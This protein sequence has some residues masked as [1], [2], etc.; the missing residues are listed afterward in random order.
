MNEH[1]LT[2]DLSDLN[3]LTPQTIEQSMAALESGQVVHFPNYSFLLDKTETALLSESVLHPKHKNISYDYRKQRLAG[4]STLASPE[5]STV[6][7]LFMHRFAEYARQLITEIVPRYSNDLVWGKTSYRPAEVQNR[8]LSK[9]K[10]DS[11][12]HVDA[13]PSTPVYGQRILRVFCNIN[14]DDAPRIWE[15]GEPFSQVLNRFS[16]TISSYSALRAR[17]L[18]W[19][20]AS[21]TIRSPY[22]HFMLKLHD[23]MKL[24]NHYQQ[25]LNKQRIDFPAKSTWIV[26]T[27]H[28]SHA[29]LGGQ[30]LLEQTF[31]LPIKAMKR[32]ELSPFKQWEALAL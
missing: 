10:D 13:F 21:K 18:M 24:D 30:Y 5:L 32:P 8:K 9:R 1:L 14:P 16:S 6:T 2:L 28:V 4:L 26:F 25:S 15:L 20:K 27:D 17:L 11:R 23:K 29:A 19:L 31:Y 22:D 7:S 12:I 3:A